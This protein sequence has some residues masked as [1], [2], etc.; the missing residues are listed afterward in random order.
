VA[1]RVAISLRAEINLDEI[2]LYL[3]TEWSIKVKEDFLALLDKKI[4]FISENPWMYQIHSKRKSIR[5]CVIGH[6]NIPYYRILTDEIEI[7]T[8]QDGRKNPKKL[9]L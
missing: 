8:I 2:V 7:I 3:E 6:H 4:K 5:R 1:Y 9:R